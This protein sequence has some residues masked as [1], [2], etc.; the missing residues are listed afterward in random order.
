MAIGTKITGLTPELEENVTNNTLLYIVNNN[1][2]KQ[3]VLDNLIFDGIIVADKIG[4][5][6]VIAEKIKTNA[7]EAKHLK[8]NAITADK[9]QAGLI[10]AE[11]LR[12]T[13]TG[14]INPSTIGAAE[15]TAF[16]NALT[17]ISNLQGSVSNLEATSDGGINTFYETDQPANPAIGDLWFDTDD[18]QLYRWNGAAWDNI[19]DPDIVQAITD[20]ANAAATA[21]KKITT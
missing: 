11:M 8:A 13:G 1:E 9:I 2:S 14:A 16:G 17:D 5:N 12:I 7:I 21:D 10:T 19:R 15:A 20:A 18:N 3:I 4:I 6:A